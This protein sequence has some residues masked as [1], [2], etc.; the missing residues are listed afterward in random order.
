L[1]PTFGASGNGLASTPGGQ[2]QGLTTC[3]AAVAAS[4]GLTTGV[5]RVAAQLDPSG[6][7]NTEF[8]PGGLLDI[9]KPKGVTINAVQQPSAR[10]LFLAG[11]VGKEIFVARYRLSASP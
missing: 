5:G 3:G 9:G 1:D 10:R 7:P 6:S 11:S 2:G 8:A 4:G